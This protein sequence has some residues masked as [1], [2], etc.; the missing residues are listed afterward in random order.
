[1]LVA[2]HIHW[3]N[4]QNQSRRVVLL[5]SYIHVS[6]I[7]FLWESRGHSRIKVNKRR[8]FKKKNPIFKQIWCISLLCGTAVSTVVN[9]IYSFV[10]MQRACK[11]NH[12]FF[13]LGF[14]M[15]VV[16]KFCGHGLHI[17][18]N[19]RTLLHTY[20]ICNKL[21]PKCQNFHFHPF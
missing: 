17:R 2:G 16:K 19:R 10:L 8:N 9:V 18:I 15:N 7:R 20:V 4:H 11:M 21:C 13:L 3:V 14:A 12:S 5:I 6:L 1:M